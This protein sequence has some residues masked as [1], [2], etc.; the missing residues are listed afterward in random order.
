MTD[1]T[2]V[3]AK[4]RSQSS[5][6][7]ASPLAMTGMRT[8]S[9]TG[10]S[11][12]QCAGS[13]GRSSTVRTCTPMASAP[14]ASI[15]RAKSAV[16]ASSLGSS[17]RMRIL[18]VTG[19]AKLRR[20]ARRMEAA[21]SGFCSSAA[22]MPPCSEKRFGQPMLMSRPA[23]SRATTVAACTAV[24][25]SATPICTTLRPT[26]SAHVRYT[27]SPDEC[28]KSTVPKT[29]LTTRSHCRNL[30]AMSSSE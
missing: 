9:T 24:T 23:Q 25:S 10:A 6:V 11:A 27:F 16:A 29:S 8:A 15:C 13:F 30:S 4:M 20:S 5:H 18:H 22:P 3:S 19:T 26:S 2:P 14:A 28:T 7:N 17:P 21:T 1:A 12:G